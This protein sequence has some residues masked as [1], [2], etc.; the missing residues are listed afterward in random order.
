[1][2]IFIIM[3]DR[4]EPLLQLLPWIEGNEII[5]VDNDSKY[6]KLLE[7]YKENPYNLKIIRTGKNFAHRSPWLMKLVPTTERYVVTDPDVIPDPDCPRDF[8][9]VMNAILDEAPDIQKVG[10]GLRI[11]NLPDHYALKENVI[12]WETGLWG[13]RRD[14]LGYEGHEVPIDTTFALYREGTTIGNY[15]SPT[16]IFPALRLGPPY[17]ARHL[18]WYSDSANPT[19]EDVYYKTRANKQIANW[20]FDDVSSSHKR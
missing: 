7:F 6:K 2:K 5:L 4:L 13:C 19:R 15:S 20:L 9:D 12:K 10:F 17:V 1:M 3:R 16:E 18:P 14:V 11:D 8:L